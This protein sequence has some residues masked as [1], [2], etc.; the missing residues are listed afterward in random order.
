MSTGRDAQSYFRIFN[1]WLQQRKFDPD[2]RY[3]H[4]WIP[5]LRGAAPVAIHRWHGNTGGQEYPAPVVDHGAR[6]AIAMAFFMA[7]T[8]AKTGRTD[9]SR[10]RQRIRNH[11]DQYYLAYRNPGDRRRGY[12]SDHGVRT[13]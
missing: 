10:S 5:R 9:N 8:M 1:P 3:I 12:L 6:S 2:C 4:R 11:Y 7:A 13:S